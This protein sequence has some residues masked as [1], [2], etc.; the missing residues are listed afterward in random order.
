LVRANEGEMNGKAIITEIQGRL[1]FWFSSTED[2][3][4]TKEKEVETKSL[5]GADH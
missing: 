5:K 1:G 4:K 2:L 3:E